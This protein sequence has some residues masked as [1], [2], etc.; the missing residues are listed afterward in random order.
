MTTLTLEVPDYLAEQIR[1]LKPR[2]PELLSRALDLSAETPLTV[3]APQKPH[4]AFE[5]MLDFLAGGPSPEK[6]VTFKAS[7][8]VQKRLE[9]LM[10]KKKEGALSE[11]ENEEL[12][13]FQQVNHIF[14]LLKT[15][16]RKQLYL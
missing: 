11:E 10:D 16:A 7:S 8:K 12:D 1:L 15:R 2:M 4:P 14:I 5:E 13:V 6:I 3:P 9:S